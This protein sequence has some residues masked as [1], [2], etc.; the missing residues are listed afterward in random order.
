M[1]DVQVRFISGECRMLESVKE[2]FQLAEQ[3]PD[4]WKISWA[5]G[6]HR[7]RL[8][9][10]NEYYQDAVKPIWLYEPLDFGASGDD[11]DHF[12]V[13][14]PPDGFCSCGAILY[15]STD[16]E[17]VLEPEET[18]DDAAAWAGLRRDWEKKIYENTGD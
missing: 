13:F 4:I 15:G 17:H 2:A 14:I 10:Q 6:D 16:G 5:E 11:P 8:V 3:E 9:R 1:T 12:H 18:D 7:V